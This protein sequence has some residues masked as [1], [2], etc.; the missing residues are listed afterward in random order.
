MKIKRIAGS[1]GALQGQS[2][3]LG[4]GLNL[5]EAPNESGKSTWCALL[6]TLFYGINTRERDSKTAL[7]DKNRY[8]PWSGAPMEGELLLTV[9]GRDL[10]LR[11]RSRG[12]PFDTFSAV[13]AVTGESVALLTGE[14]AG[15][16]LLGVSR[17]VFERSAF[18]GQG[19]QLAPAGSAEL[20]KRIAALVSSGEEAVSHSQ[21]EGRLREWLRRRRHNKT[22]LIPRLEEELADLDAQL[23][24]L[25]ALSG[26]VVQNS[27]REKELEEA[28]RQITDDLVVWERLEQ[29][30]QNQRYARR[31]AE[32]EQ[33][34]ARA[35][36]SR[37]ALGALGEVAPQA[38][39]QGDRLMG[40]WSALDGQF[41]R[42]EQ[43]AA[44]ARAEAQ[45]AQA[46][47]GIF[48]FLGMTPD[49][50]WQRADEDAAAVEFHLRKA[51]GSGKR[52]AIG[53][54]AGLAA[55]GVLSAL[56]FALSPLLP[57][58][59][60]AIGCVVFA[61]CTV[62]SLAAGKSS[63]RRHEEEKDELLEGYGV[64]NAA[65]IRAMAGEFREKRTLADRA[66]DAARAK[67]EGA[68]AL[69]AQCRRTLEELLA[70]VRPFAPNATTAA[71][72]ALAIQ[73]ARALIQKAR[74]DAERCQ[75]AKGIFDLIAEQG[76]SE[77]D[78]LEYL[79]P[80]SRSREELE[81]AKARA[82][83]QLSDVRAALA[84]ARGGQATVGDPAMLQARR[85]QVWEQLCRRRE[86]YD[87]IALALE[88]LE[89]A[90]VK[91]RSRI[92]P[93]LNARAGALFSALTGGAY[94]AVSLSRSFDAEARRAGAL[95][96][97]GALSLSQG[98]ADQLYLAVR[99]ALCQMLL[100]AEQGAPIVLDDVLCTF[101]D[102]RMALA[103]QVLLDIAKERQV[104]LFT[105]HTREGQW[106]REQGHPCR[107]PLS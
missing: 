41:R 86:E 38:L 106:L 42:S 94:E 79:E 24:R 44:A 76:G 104:L 98:T 8:A 1:F 89:G 57:S 9:D 84:E 91:F 59:C 52:S 83:V 18:V 69:H 78:T 40:Q 102:R 6:R 22:G 93:E 62:I 16:T 11:R 43:E 45:A 77:A 35:E 67:E 47:G 4:Q 92:S 73:N 20:E 29:H 17:E 48:P 64:D 96:P 30:A 54:V 2:L 25:S 13:D 85:E 61:G 81:E 105:C 53:A 74:E 87:A 49:Q 32:W 23:G 3:E 37:R 27:A 95:L 36:A 19:G 39:E 60:V 82:A 70:L 107:F 46:D 26:A 80:P 100:P 34:Q 103:L 28:L 66:E 5:I 31:K 88:A 21:V 58:V 55:G 90:A 14:N 33:A 101:D 97:R 75:S 72:A 7:A 68:Q 65:A 15:E 12:A 71:E 51:R 56:L 63:Q 50:A 99:L 10:L